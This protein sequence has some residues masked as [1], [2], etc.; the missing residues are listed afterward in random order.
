MSIDSCTFIDC[1][2]GLDGK[3]CINIDQAVQGNIPS[4]GQWDG[5]ICHGVRITNCLFKNCNGIAGDHTNMYYRSTDIV[6][7]GCVALECDQGIELHSYDNV[8]V[9][10]CHI[11]SDTYGIRIHNVTACVISNVTLHG[12]ESACI[13]INTA[14]VV[15]SGINMGYAGTDY[16]VE[17]TDATMIG[18]GVIETGGGGQGFIHVNT[19]SDIMISVFDIADALDSTK[20]IADGSVYRDM[21]RNG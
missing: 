5:T 17:C 15:I 20:L 11:H 3:E 21:T 2:K 8:I 19:A 4:M 16:A 1:A 12:Q 10:D 13:D 14:D 18:T 6:L 7:S 9:S